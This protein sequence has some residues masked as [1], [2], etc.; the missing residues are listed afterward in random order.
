ML[1]FALLFRPRVAGRVPPLGFLLVW[2]ALAVS[3]LSV[4]SLSV[5]RAEAPLPE[6]RGRVSDGAR[7]LS[8]K[9]AQAL[10]TELARYESETGHQFAFVSIETLDGAALEDFSMRLAEKWKLGD[11]KRDDG[12]ILL[13]AKAERKMRIE[14]GYGLEGV[15]PDALGAQIIRNELRPAFQA[16]DFDG[17]ITR[18]FALLERAAEGEAIQAQGDKKKEGGR[19]LFRLLPLL[20]FALILRGMT[21]GG[22]GGRGFLAGAILG[23]LAGRSF[24]GR[25]GGFG[26]GG[27]GFGGGFGGGGGG[28]G[29]G[30]ASG[31]W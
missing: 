2:L 19:S 29:G 18:A 30:G 11:E 28:F 8:P 13:V 20:I 5:A 27:G 26:G 15:I 10:E 6:L 22:R 9:V 7:I 25:R 31:G 3:S 21:S 17:G 14:V 4:L 23:G 16:N 1:L 12:L 24:G